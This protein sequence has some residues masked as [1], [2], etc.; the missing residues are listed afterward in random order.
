VRIGTSGWQ[1]KHWRG[2]F[3]D[4]NL[5]VSG[6]LPAYYR[7]FDTVEI[8]NSF[9]KLPSTA[10][11]ENW[12]ASTPEDFIF[13]VKASRFITH[14]KKL[15]DPQNGLD[16]L[17]P[18]AEKL[19]RKLGPILFQFPPGWSVNTE[20][21]EN[22]LRA[23]PPKHRYTFE[24]R[25]QTWHS[26]CVYNLLRHYNAAFCIF[27]L[28]GFQSE[29]EITADFTYVRLHGPG[30]RYQGSY[31]SEALDHWANRIRD[32]KRKLTGIYVYFDNDQ[33]GYAAANALELRKCL[34]MQTSRAA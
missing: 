9:Y 4:P 28:A 12:R 18:R 25:N 22:F 31:S 33:A 32:W 34:A 30:G 6:M 8:N 1:Y 27:D 20:R 16:N 7:Q 26:T 13:A 14:M 23:L 2:S 15:K 21:L 24:F 5:P 19:D 10:A 17:L 29:L 3:Y 11:F